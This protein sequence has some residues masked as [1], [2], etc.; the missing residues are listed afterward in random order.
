MKRKIINLAIRCATGFVEE[1]LG[2]HTSEK[3]PYK[4]DINKRISLYMAQHEVL[5]YN[6]M[7]KQSTSES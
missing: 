5:D 1:P 6:E 3:S 7:L 4:C 2:I